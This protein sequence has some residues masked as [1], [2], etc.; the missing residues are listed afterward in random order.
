[1][2]LRRDLA[3]VA[4]VDLVVGPDHAHQRSW[5]GAGTARPWSSR[6]GPGE[7]PSPSLS[8]VTVSGIELSQPMAD[9]LHKKR[10]NIPV[11]VGDMATRTTPGTFSLVYVV[12]NSIGN[13]R[14]Q[15]EQVACYRNAAHH[16]AP[17]GRFVVEMGGVPGNPF[18]NDSDSHSP[19][20]ANQS[21]PTTHLSRTSGRA[22]D[23]AAFGRA[24]G[25]AASAPSG[26]WRGG[27][28]RSERGDN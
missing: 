9:Q 18:T 1:M 25:P 28:V 13:L 27:V 21:E 12:W 22:A 15:A 11:L 16:L 5:P 20:G 26:T 19:S 10:N 7:S 8:G 4:E 2:L 14:T 3:E 24:I 17:G 6:S 23:S